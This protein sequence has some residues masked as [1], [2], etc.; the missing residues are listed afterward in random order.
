MAMLSI[1]VIFGLILCALAYQA[2]AR[3]RS[4]DRLPMQWWVTGEV[5]WSAPRRLALTFI[6]ALAVAVLS[7]FA[8]MSLTM[9]PRAGQEALVVPSLIGLGVTFIAIQLAHFWLIAKTLRRPA[10]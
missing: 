8:I 6:P 1:A 10:D 3:F 2:N 5:T 7:I 9:K 4:E